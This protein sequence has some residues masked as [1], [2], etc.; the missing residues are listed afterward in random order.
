M[1]S[2]NNFWAEKVR[3]LNKKLK[4]AKKE[5][6]RLRAKGNDDLMFF[7][8]EDMPEYTI[9]KTIRDTQM[10]LLAIEFEALKRA[11]KLSPSARREG[12]SSNAGYSHYL[13]RKYNCTE[14]ELENVFSR[15]NP[16]GYSSELNDMFDESMNQ[17]DANSVVRRFK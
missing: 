9:P 13:L 4:E 16:K 12:F 8:T 1:I 2:K 3:Q 17:K 5:N 15:M 7:V 10:Q 14:E 11:S 6:K